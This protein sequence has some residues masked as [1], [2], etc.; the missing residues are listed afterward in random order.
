MFIEKSGVL[1]K[2]HGNEYITL[3]RCSTHG[4]MYDITNGEIN[5]DYP[6]EGIDELFTVLALA[7]DAYPSAGVN[8][9]DYSSQFEG[10]TD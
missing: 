4:K 3:K 8:Q 6:P 7:K 10:M 1:S 2:N 5:L 9:R